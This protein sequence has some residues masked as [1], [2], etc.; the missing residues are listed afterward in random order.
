LILN[1]DAATTLLNSVRFDD[2]G[3]I[4]AIAQDGT[5]HIVL[6]QA[7][8]NQ[9]ALYMTLTTGYAHYWSRSRQQL[10]KKGETSSNLQHVKEVRLDCDQDS[11]LLLV[12]QDGVACHTGTYHCHYLKATNHGWSKSS[13]LDTLTQKASHIKELMT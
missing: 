3:L 7:W 9:E 11:I 13:L 6:M 12:Q 8:M 5:T 10:W 4:V 2:N 1:H